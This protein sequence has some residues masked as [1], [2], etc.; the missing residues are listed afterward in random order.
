[1]NEDPT[2]AL[3]DALTFHA[4]FDNGVDADFARGDGT[5]YTQLQLR[6]QLEVEEGLPTEV[7]LEESGRFG[8]CLFFNTP[9]EVKG[10]RTFYK[11]KD[12]LE[13]KEEDWSGTISFWLRVTPDEDLRPGY[14]DP[15]QLTP[16]SALD[17]CLWVDS[18]WISTDN[19]AW[20]H[21]RIRSLGI[22]TTNRTKRFL[23]ANAP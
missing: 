13:F 16:R 12:N 14:T 10:T 22:L 5:M 7:L 3:Q 23:T 1:M 17:S 4:S 6:P 18:V 9:D 21:F 11:L 19:F 15:I 8:N 20:G 2:I